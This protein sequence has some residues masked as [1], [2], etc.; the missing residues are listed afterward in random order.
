MITCTSRQGEVDDMSYVE[1]TRT[2]DDDWNEVIRTIFFKD[3]K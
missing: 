3:E 2:W 1:K